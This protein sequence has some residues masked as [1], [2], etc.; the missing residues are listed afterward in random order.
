MPSMTVSTI[1]ILSYDLLEKKLIY[2]IKKTSNME[3]ITIEF[4]FFVYL[5]IKIDLLKIERKK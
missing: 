5:Y 2:I 1:A 4:P 3:R